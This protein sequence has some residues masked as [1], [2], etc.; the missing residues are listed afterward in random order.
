MYIG[1]NVPS[2]FDPEDGAD[3]SALLN[4]GGGRCINAI[5]RSDPPPISG[6]RDLEAGESWCDTVPTFNGRVLQAADQSRF[7]NPP[8]G[9]TSYFA[10]PCKG[11]CTRPPDSSPSISTHTQTHTHTNTHTHTTTLHA[12]ACTH[13]LAHTHTHQISD[14]L[15][16]CAAWENPDCPH[17]D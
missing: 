3:Q 15:G 13:A 8:D 10:F 11:S 17:Q 4:H 14:R 7:C 12:R 2:I 1:F 9:S 16:E 5:C 6:I